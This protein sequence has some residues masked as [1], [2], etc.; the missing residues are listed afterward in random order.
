MTAS[1]YRF[2]DFL[3]DP[4]TREL[5][6]RGKPVALPPKSFDCLAYLVAHHDRAVGRDELISAVWG[7]IDVNDALLAQTLLRAR[8]AVGDTGSR[9][10]TIRTVPRFG[11][12]WIRAVERIDPAPDL[13]TTGPRS[14]RRPTPGRTRLV[15]VTAAL[16]VM[17]AV[18]IL[19]AVN[20]HRGSGPAPRTNARAPIV[21][22]PVTLA[23][24]GPEDA[25][26][27]LGAMDY[28]AARLREDG[29]LSV[30]PSEQVVS[31]IGSHGDR[32]AATL[33]HIADVTGAR[34]IV[35]PALARSGNGWSLDL[36]DTGGGAPRTVSADGATPLA[37][38]AH[39]CARLLR[40]WG[41]APRT[42]A[43]PV[44]APD[45]LT[46]RLQR[47]DAAILGGNLP[48]ARDLI[49]TA[50]PTERADPRLRVREGQLEFRAGR[51]DEAQTL[52]DAIV[53][54]DTP[55]PVAVRAPASM[56]LGA[57]A[58]RRGDYAAA[59][60]RYAEALAVL[61][62]DGDPDLVG[63]AYSGRGV[64]RGAQH[65]FD[66]ALTDLG[67]AR[68]ALER[69]GNTLDAASVDTNL[70]LIEG[71]RQRY[72]Q[73]IAPFDR[74][75]DT[76]ERYGV[77]D[78]LA[79][80]LLGKA[81]AQ[82]AL[83]DLA[84]ALATSARAF[85]IAGRLENPELVRRIA[86]ADAD[87]LLQNGKLD[88]A[89]KVL[90][91]VESRDG[92]DGEWRSLRAALALARGD[93]RAA[94]AAV[95]GTPHAKVADDR[96]P[97][98]VA[99]ALAAGNQDAAARAVADVGRGTHAPVPIELARGELAAARGQHETALAH[100]GRADAAARN[101]GVPALRVQAGAAYARALIGAGKT[102]QASAIVGDLAP[103]A[104]RDFRVAQV[105]ALL[106]H[107]LGDRS[108]ETRARAKVR[109]LA[110]ERDPE[111]IVP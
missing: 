11:Y 18:A 83:V 70:G 96:L 104:N 109:A 111:R 63:L 23:D 84:G 47:I 95:T 28:I 59:E 30:L 74:A 7:R 40:H 103:Y 32:D 71:S 56:G 27:R 39:A 19:L 46:E 20:P 60:K 80:S 88:E 108:L 107:A 17:A 21:V 89:G 87:A 62:D 55:L 86:L 3:L 9:Q 22:L 69:A 31:L 81:R 48:A 57:V 82:L 37:A 38:A 33:A 49:D 26:I 1:S 78:N 106:F 2:G 15:A 97:L 110:G 64:A 45:A 68:V 6:C 35:R 42:D 79:A 65:H 50:S 41:Q 61:G 77:E 34:H 12:H 85:A 67:R 66:L 91:G 25:W 98:Y 54:Q 52:F 73:A 90:G 13:A 14:A 99:A 58:V 43:A 5:H 93:P 51:I 92:G 100:F 102:D 53:R 76:F 75:I 105:T 36:T 24:A 72:A 94:L 4:A 10:D 44:P 29:A 16:T 8:R 101:A